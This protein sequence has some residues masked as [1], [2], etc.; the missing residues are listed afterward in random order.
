[1][2]QARLLQLPV[3]LLYLIVDNLHGTEK[4]SLSS[5]CKDLRA[6]IAP[7]AF[8][9]VTR[10]PMKPR[11]RGKGMPSSYIGSQLG[12]GANSQ[13]FFDLIES[14]FAT[15]STRTIPLASYLPLMSNLSSLDI[16]FFENSVLC[17]IYKAARHSPTIRHLGIHPLLGV[18]ENL[19]AFDS[20]PTCRLESLLVP[21]AVAKDLFAVDESPTLGSLQSIELSLNWGYSNLFSRCAPQLKSL[22]QMTITAHHSIS[23]HETLKLL[24]SLPVLEEMIIGQDT[25]LP[26]PG[27]EK[28]QFRALCRLEASSAAAMHIL[29]HVQSSMRQIHLTLKGWIRDKNGWESLADGLNLCQDLK[30]VTIFNEDWDHTHFVMFL[31][32]ISSNAFQRLQYLSLNHYTEDRSLEFA[33][34]FE[35]IAEALKNK[36]SPSCVIDLKLPGV[37]D[38]THANL[39]D[40]GPKQGHRSLLKASIKWLQLHCHDLV[41]SWVGRPQ[42]LPLRSVSL[43]SLPGTV[44]EYR[45]GATGVEWMVIFEPYEDNMAEAIQSLMGG[46]M[47][48]PLL[49]QPKPV[50]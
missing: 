12:A 6:I 15:L 5:C 7:I 43:H 32:K 35:E 45:Q 30:E 36:V 16:R 27:E 48:M 34:V 4:R 41:N 38:S 1:M 25:V 19:P 31:N 11:S 3:E 39:L 44:V 26:L 29:P 33:G 17:D 14:I 37:N 18:N 24:T 42:E 28:A 46:E 9:T 23:K 47:I 10:L 13:H 49:V 50:Q 22:R 40:L 2:S 8:R 20:I 21:P